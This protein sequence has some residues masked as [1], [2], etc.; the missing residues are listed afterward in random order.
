[1]TCPHCCE[2]PAPTPPMFALRT[3]TINIDAD[4]SVTV[5]LMP[6]QLSNGCAPHGWVRV[7]T[8]RRL[9]DGSLDK[10]EFGLSPEALAAINTAALKFFSEKQ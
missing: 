8:V 6:G 10:T 2:L 3:E 9:P 4:R 1:M 5:S 7:Q